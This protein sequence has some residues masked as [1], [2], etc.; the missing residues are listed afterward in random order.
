MDQ[1]VRPY[2]GRILVIGQRVRV[3]RNLHAQCYSVMDARTRLVLAH[4]VGVRLENAHC[5]VSPEGRRRVV[6]TGHKTVHAWVEGDFV[7]GMKFL[8]FFYDDYE[9]SNYNPREVA[10][11]VN[12]QTG[13]PVFGPF[14]EVIVGHGVHYKEAA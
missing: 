10:T 2:K 3:Y 1:F 12:V 11:F 6:E 9:V 7:T 5:H 8:S 13:E 14:A 4:A